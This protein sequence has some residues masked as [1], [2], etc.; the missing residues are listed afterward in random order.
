MNA[1]KGSDLERGL[2]ELYL[3]IATLAE[4]QFGY[5]FRQG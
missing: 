3:D 4:Q 2:A 5:W 1:P